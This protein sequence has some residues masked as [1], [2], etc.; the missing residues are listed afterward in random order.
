MKRSAELVTDVMTL[1]RLHAAL[2]SVTQTEQM[3]TQ[4]QET[5]TRSSP[6]VVRVGTLVA[7]ARELLRLLLAPP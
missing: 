1:A 3:I 4:I 5:S 2:D 7:E 6:A